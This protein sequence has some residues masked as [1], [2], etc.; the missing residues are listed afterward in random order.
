MVEFLGL[1][2]DSL[3]RIFETIFG[4]SEK[5]FRTVCAIFFMC[6]Y[7]NLNNMLVV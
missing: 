6:Y 5:D 3:D 1:F 4:Q 7:K 2:L